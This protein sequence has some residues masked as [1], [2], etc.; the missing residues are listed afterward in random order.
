[1]IEVGGRSIVRVGLNLRYF[2]HTAEDALKCSQLE[3]TGI[4][5]SPRGLV[6]CGF[7]SCKHYDA[8]HGVHEPVTGVEL[9]K[10]CSRSRNVVADLPSLD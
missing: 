8:R 7:K 4:E 6:E 2:K 1:M 5:N 9:L 10:G 3:N